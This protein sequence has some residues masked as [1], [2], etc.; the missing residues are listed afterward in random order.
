MDLPL[1]N[2]LS[3]Y[4]D[5]TVNQSSPVL[6]DNVRVVKHDEKGGEVVSYEPFDSPK[7]QESLGQVDNWDLESLLAAGIDPRFGIHT[8]ANTRLENESGLRD[9]IIKAD[10]IER[11]LKSE[12]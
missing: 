2:V 8:G 12:E 11:S 5:R 7:Y 3:K 10:E 9:F 1:E 6:I 4:F